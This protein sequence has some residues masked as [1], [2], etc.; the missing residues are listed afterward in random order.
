M[1]RARGIYKLLGGRLSIPIEGGR[2]RLEEMFGE[3]LAL[4]GVAEVMEKHD[5]QVLRT[6]KEPL[7]ASPI[8]IVR[9]E[10]QNASDHR[11]RVRCVS[12]GGQYI[13]PPWSAVPRCECN[14]EFMEYEATLLPS[15]PQSHYGCFIRDG[16]RKTPSDFTR[17]AAGNAE[18][19]G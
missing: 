18:G 16:K 5:V 12:C 11:V 2:T 4:P 6:G 15:E 13:L 17:G 1:R 3:L 8:R 14:Q 7:T 10:L 19:Q 9:T